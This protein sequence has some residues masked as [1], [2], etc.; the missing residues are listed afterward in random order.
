MPSSS[1]AIAV[2]F[3]LSLTRSESE[4]GRILSEA[5][6]RSVTVIVAFDETPSA[7]AETVV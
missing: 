1:S 7:V 2:R 6:S 4:V 3:S 5:T